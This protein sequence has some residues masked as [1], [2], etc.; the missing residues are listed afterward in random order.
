[1]RL[2]VLTPIAT[3]GG[4]VLGFTALFVTVSFARFRSR[5]FHYLVNGST[6]G[7]SFYHTNPDC[8]HGAGGVQVLRSNGVN[9][10]GHKSEG[11]FVTLWIRESSNIVY[12]GFGGFAAPFAINDTYPAG[13]AQ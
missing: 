5:Y 11:N 8:P 1:M 6:T 2:A 7:L 3:S 9:I 10:F 4:S 13:Y 12:T